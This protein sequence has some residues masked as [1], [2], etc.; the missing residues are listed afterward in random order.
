MEVSVSTDVGWHRRYRATDLA[1][2]ACFGLAVP[3]IVSL[4]YPSGYLAVVIG[5][6]HDR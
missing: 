3:A 2:A 1:A 5:V 4:G 6:L